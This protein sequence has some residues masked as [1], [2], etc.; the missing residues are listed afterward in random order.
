MRDRAIVVALALAVVGLGF[1][2][3]HYWVANWF[4]HPLGYCTGPNCK[5]YQFWSGIVGDIGEVTLIGSAVLLFRH[6]NCHAPWCWRRGVHPT[7]DGMF[8]LC[9]KH[10]PDLPNKK[11][12]LQE[13]HA[14]HKKAL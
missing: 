13:I 2:A 8:K 9:R 7:A 6:V 14:R 11:L 3:L 12:T 5:G 4:W 1:L 10:H